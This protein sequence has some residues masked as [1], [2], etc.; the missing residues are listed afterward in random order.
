MANLS[1]GTFED[2]IKLFNKSSNKVQKLLAKTYPKFYNKMVSKYKNTIEEGKGKL[3]QFEK[4]YNNRKPEPI[5]RRPDPKEFKA[6]TKA[7]GSSLV[8]KGGRVN[9]PSVPNKVYTPN[10]TMTNRLNLPQ[11]VNT[12]SNIISNVRPTPTAN[13][14][15]I[16]LSNI[17]DSI[18]GDEGLFSRMYN[19][20]KET[21]KDIGQKASEASKNVGGKAGKGIIDKVKSFKPTAGG[22][23]KGGLYGGL[24]TWAMADPKTTWNQKILGAG[25]MVPHPLTRGASLVGLGATAIIPKAVDA[26]YDY[27]DPTKDV[28]S[29]YNFDGYMN[30]FLRTEG[31][32]PELKELTPEQKAKIQAGYNAQV[33]QKFMDEANASQQDAYNVANG[34]APQEAQAPSANSV[35]SN[36]NIPAQP[37]FVS[38]SKNIQNAQNAQQ[39]ALNNSQDNLYLGCNPMGLTSNV[40]APVPSIENT[41]DSSMWNADARMN[42][43]DLMNM[44]NAQQPQAVQ[45]NTYEQGTQALLE[46]LKQQ[47][48]KYA[49][50]KAMGTELLKQYQDAV[51][52]DRKQNEINQL[53]NSFGVFGTPET[54]APIYYIG[55][56]GDMRKVEL[57]QPSKVEPLSVNTSSNVDNV[58]AQYKLQSALTPKDNNAMQQVLTAQA[59]GD[60]Y[61]VNPLIFLNPDLAKTYLTNQGTLENT[62]VTAQERRGD[63]PLNTMS[64]IIEQDVKTAGK[65]AED[66]ANNAFDYYMLMYKEAGYNDRQAQELASREAINVYNQENQNWRALLEDQRARDLAEYGRGTQWGVADIYAGARGSQEEDPLQRMYKGSQIIGN[67]YGLPPQQ[68]QQALDYLNSIAGGV[69]TQLNIN[70]YGT[71]IDQD[72]ILRKARERNR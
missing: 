16:P 58:L 52:R 59:L 4:D 51:A 20:A 30:D 46:Y 41:P 68:R 50:Q 39:G 44:A 72:S 31:L 66:K 17:A 11:V 9:V 2:F 67:V 70:P 7:Q 40:M 49:E 33:T 37:Q 27:T 14:N 61:G 23:I 6:P 62:R 32:A 29:P 55:A 63:I 48:A 64:K 1:I 21:V 22:L 56:K 5:K 15:A 12:G 38:P 26:Y 71:T 13:P 8:P 42:M 35:T 45:P 69:N 18:N 53:V 10:F 36:T 19:Q 54:K 28:N 24:G 3:K 60:Q 57:N 25:V 65:M 47:N 34:I 43:N